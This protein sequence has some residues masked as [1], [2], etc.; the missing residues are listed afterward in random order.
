MAN[1]C[2][3]AT[4]RTAARQASLP[5]TIF[6]FHWV[7]DAIQPSA[8]LPPPFSSWPQSF[9]APQGLFQWIG[10]LYQVAKVLEL[11]IP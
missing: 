5:F 7:N 2:L 4:P 1:L 6:H 11:Q 8:P 10:S 3:T 9:P